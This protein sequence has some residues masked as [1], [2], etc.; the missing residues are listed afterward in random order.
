MIFNT[1]DVKALYPSIQ[2]T[3]LFDSL[4]DCFKRC[5]KWTNHQIALLLELI[6]Y[7]LQNQQIQWNQK[8]YTF[9]QGLLT[10]GKHSVPLANIF[11]SYIMRELLRTNNTFK[12]IFQEEIML[13]KQ[14]ID[15]IGGLS[16]GY[17]AFL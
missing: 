9:K 12:T 17:I 14:F 3:Y 7:T 8:L 13:W 1:I 11:L 6:F 5:T 16:I 10:G 15:G 2:F 4:K